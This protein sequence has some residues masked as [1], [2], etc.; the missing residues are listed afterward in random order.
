MK[1]TA[2]FVAGTILIFL[3]CTTL[4]LKKSAYDYSNMDRPTRLAHYR[5]EKFLENCIEDQDPVALSQYT[6]IDSVVIDREKDHIDVYFNRML[7]HIPFREKNTRAIYDEMN[8]VM[9]RRFSP[10]SL[11]IYSRIFLIE[12]LIPNYFRKDL[13]P[14]DKTRLARNDNQR[15]PVV[16]RAGSREK[17]SQGLYKH[18][19]ALWH[20]HGWYYEQALNRW[21]WQRAR[22]FQ[23]V[24]DLGPMA[25]TIPYLIPMLENAGANV[26]VPRERDLQLNEVI[27]DND[28]STAGS[29]YFCSDEQMWQ[30]ENDKG[31]AIGNPPYSAGENPFQNGTFFKLKVIPE[32][33][34]HIEWIPDIPEKGEYAVSISYVAS[35]SNVTDARYA[36]YH[37]GGISEFLVNQRIGGSTWIYLGTFKFEKG[38]NNNTGKVVLTSKNGQFGEYIT[39]DAVRFGGGM[40][41]VER[42]GKISGRPRFAEAARYYLQYAGLPDTLVYSLNG[43]TSD[44]RDDYQCRGE[45]VNYLKGNPYGPNLK[46]S[47]AGLGIPVDLSLAFHTDAGISA[48]DT[49]IGTLAIYSSWDADSALVFP[50]SVYRLAN[51]DFADIMQT[52]IVEDL[53]AKYDPVWNRRGLWDRQYSEAYRP[54]TPSALLELLSH[55]NYLD[56]QFAHDPRFRFD[57]SRS[58]YKAIL[59]FVA[60][61]NEQ[62]YTIQPLPV[63][64]FQ[65][66]F[67]ADK[68]VDLR[69]QPVEDPLEPSAFPEKYVVYTRIDDQGFDNGRI[70]NEAE[71]KIA[72]L[73]PGRI[74]S[75]K[76]AAINAGGESFPSEILSV[77]WQDGI[78][79]V[80]IING[81]DRICGPEGIRTDKFTGFVNILDMGVPDKF[82]L[83]YTGAQ[84]NFSPSSPWTDDDAPGFGASHADYETMVVAGN[85]FDYVYTHGV[86]LQQ[87]GQSFVSASDESVSAGKLKIDSYPM[88]DIILGE[89]K[90]TKSP[91]SFFPDQFETFPIELRSRI[92]GYCRAGGR[93]FISGAYVGT[94]LC[95]RTPVDSQAIKFAQDTLK[96]FWRTNHAATKGEFY[97]V[98]AQFLDP[99]L[100]G[101]FCAHLNPDI[102]MVE[103]PDGIEPADTTATSLLRYRENNISAAIGYKGQYR[104]VIFGFPFETILSLEQRREIMQAVLTYLDPNRKFT[105]K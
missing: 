4:G 69:W 15:I 88:V 72:H 70:V 35:D 29:E 54:N 92:T 21:E 26:F 48:N 53:R 66:A 40:G 104:L 23:M 49:V 57:V 46:R 12:S 3:S 98:N 84:F 8:Y 97:S 105:S 1:I 64:H 56:V 93:L 82:D 103:A 60:S 52:Q 71:L 19:I 58:I 36:V 61:R 89:E 62:E 27:V 68:E 6:R 75:Y 22:L 101:R 34:T 94:D 59:R 87:L 13:Y 95:A 2:I 7:A 31:F 81:F 100:K 20:S 99:Q 32:Q 44:Y 96:L 83:G 76:V 102:Y 9:G 77:C 41:N 43:D 17:P 25:F 65:A 33:K 37:G 11:S 73:E 39:A 67:S 47:A 85:T 74:Y 18:N 78:K 50:D 14:I 79:P 91:K 86:A 51:R 5:V 16:R 30:R 80:L 45:W 90:T 28:S 24:E 38:L 55:Q 10:Y 63:S 42:G